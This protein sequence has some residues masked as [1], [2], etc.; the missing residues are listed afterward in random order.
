MKIRGDDLKIVLKQSLINSTIIEGK[1][2]RNR[3]YLKRLEKI[4]DIHK[5]ITLHECLNRKS[6]LS[7][8]LT[9]GYFILN[10]K[11]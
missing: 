6:I 11:F 8:N 2:N 3:I 1:K 10:I 7:L 5:K 9:G 4:G